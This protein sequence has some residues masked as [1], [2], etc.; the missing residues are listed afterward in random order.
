MNIQETQSNKWKFYLIIFGLV[1]VI[2]MM[3]T[4]KGNGEKVLVEVPKTSGITPIVKPLQEPLVIFQ[5]SVVLKYIPVTDKK[6]VEKWQSDAKRL[7]NE[8]IQ[9]EIAFAKSKNKDSLY[10]KSIEISEF[11]TEWDNDTINAKVFGLNTGQINSM[12]LKYTIKERKQEVKVPQTVFRL[13]GGIE[14][15]MTKDLS[16]FNVKANLGVQLKKGSIINLGVDS[17]QRFYLGFATSIFQ[18]KK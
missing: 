5:D 13:L 17:E 2:V 11:L 16:K 6:E 8:K 3:A 9:L 10:S 4:C 15:G 14:T 7:L 1:L 18:I 12:Q